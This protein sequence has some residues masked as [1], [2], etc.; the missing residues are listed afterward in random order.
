MISFGEYFKD[1]GLFTGEPIHPYYSKYDYTME[2][3]CAWFVETML[4]VMG[5]KDEF[6][7]QIGSMLKPKGDNSKY[8]GKR[9]S[10]YLRAH[11]Y[12]DKYGIEAGDIIYLS[13]FNGK[14]IKN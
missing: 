3:P 8:K 6:A 5:L 14:L 9:K 13:W 2:R 11:E 7:T 10:T 4:G 1:E 12:A